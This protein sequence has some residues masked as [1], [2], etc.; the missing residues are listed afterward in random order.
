MNIIIK[1][2]EKRSFC[3]NSGPNEVTPNPDVPSK[4]GS[5]NNT[6]GNK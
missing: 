6:E 2:I 5:D 3:P 4:T 1:D